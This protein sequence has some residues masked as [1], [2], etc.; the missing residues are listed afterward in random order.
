MPTYPILIPFNRPDVHLSYTSTRFV[1]AK[2]EYGTF[3]LVVKTYFPDE[4][5]PGGAVSDVLDL[6]PIGEEIGNRKFIIE[7]K[8][9]SFSKISLLISR[10]GIT[11]GTLCTADGEDIGR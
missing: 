8:E 11:P 9:K 4:R 5:H 10:S 6:M 3:D 2:E 7:G 1:T